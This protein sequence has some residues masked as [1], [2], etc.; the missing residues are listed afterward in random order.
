MLKVEEHSRQWAQC[1]DGAAC[2]GMPETP[3]QLDCWTLNQG[4]MKVCSP[5]KV[6]DGKKPHVAQYLR[7]NTVFDIELDMEKITCKY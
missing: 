3:L 2:P 7:L 4:Q 5:Y 6:N 1:T